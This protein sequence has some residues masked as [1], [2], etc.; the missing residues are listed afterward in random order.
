MQR[1]LQGQGLIQNHFTVENWPEGLVPSTTAPFDYAIHALNAPLTL[2]TKYPPRLGGRADFAAARSRRGDLLDLLSFAR[3]QLRGP[4]HAIG[5]RLLPCSRVDL[6]TAF[7]RPR[8]QSLI[9]ALLA[10]AL[11]AEYERWEG[12]KKG[13]HIAAGIAWGL[14]CWTS[15]YEPLT[16]VVALIV[17]NLIARRKE[18]AAF[19]ISFG[20]VMLL[21]LLVEGIHVFIPRPNIAAML[22]RWLQF[23]EEMRGMTTNEFINVITFSGVPADGW[24]WWEMGS[25]LFLLALPWIGW[26]LVGYRKQNGQVSAD[27]DVPFSRSSRFS[28][29]A[30]GTTPAS[31]KFFCSRA[32]FRPRRCMGRVWCWACSS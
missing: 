11:T 3:L 31:G 27:T 18:S 17:F 8:H 32:I 28:R 4:R 5:R 1:I 6:G 10:V 12:M 23:I 30:G 22:A 20:V 25:F 29:V 19:A 15:L 13:W 2:F 16:A 7:G 26:R 24:I 9:V 21:A 14:A